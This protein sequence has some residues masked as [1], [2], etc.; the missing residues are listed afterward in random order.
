[1][2]QYVEFIDDLAAGFDRLVIGEVQRKRSGAELICHSVEL[3]GRPAGQQQGVR[4]RQ[5]GS[6]RS[7]YAAAGAGDECSWHGSS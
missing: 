7:T 4:R 1:M 6:D 5:C 2:Y 3:G